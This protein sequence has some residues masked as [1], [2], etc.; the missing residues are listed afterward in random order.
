MN[1]Q[2]HI[3]NV[4]PGVSPPVASVLSPSA[5]ASDCSMATAS[6]LS[7][8][9]ISISQVI[10]DDCTVIMAGLWAALPNLLLL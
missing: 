8:L 2:A 5:L 4:Y 6:N 3:K 9:E 7:P 10:I 1:S